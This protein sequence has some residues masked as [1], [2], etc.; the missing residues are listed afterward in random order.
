[1]SQI[2]EEIRDIVD[3]AEPVGAPRSKKPRVPKPGDPRPVEGWKDPMF[4][5]GWRSRAWTNDVGLPRDCPVHPLGK[6]GDVFFFLDPLGQLRALKASEMGQAGIAALFAPRTEY[7]YWGWP[8]FSKD[9]EVVGWKANLIRDDLMN[10]CAHL[11]VWRS[12]SRV[13]GRG[14]WMEDDGSLTLHC[15]DV[16]VRANGEEDPGERGDFV[17]PAGVKCLKPWGE[18]VNGQAAQDLLDLLSTWRWRR[19]IDPLLLLGWISAGIL[20]G[21]LRW[22]PMMFLVGDRATGKSTLQRVISEVFGPDGMVQAAETTAAGI[23]QHVRQ[24]SVP[25]SID[26]MEAEADNRKA[27]AVV[28]LARLASSGALMLRGGAEHKGVEFT[29]RSVFGFSAINAPPMRP[30]DRSRMAFLELRPFQPG[31]KEPVIDVEDLR[32]IGRKI[33]RRL[34]DH[35]GE[36][37]ERLQTIRTALMAGGHVGR[38]A[39]QFGALLV[40]ADLLLNDTPPSSDDLQEW[41]ESLA[42]DDMVEFQDADPN[43]QRCLDHLFSKPVKA[44]GRDRMQTVGAQLADLGNPAE[45]DLAKRIENINNRLAQIG[46]AIV[47]NFDAAPGRKREFTGLWLAIPTTDAKLQ[48][49]F[50]GTDWAGSAGVGGIWSGALRQAP[51]GYWCN[52]RARIDGRQRRCILVN[53]DKIMQD[54]SE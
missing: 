32:I 27:E 45:G 22:R 25:I 23:Y 40:C 33:R 42:P 19:S 20:G 15:G 18:H 48:D 52:D 44:W 29:A 41:A 38:G 14:G 8:Q 31:D 28:K 51:D 24:D 6:D 37:D 16:L 2:E 9:L 50:E 34:L 53:L 21:F 35:H 7:L 3:A 11:G 39:D 54:G 1:M 4:A 30:Q 26:E 47:G 46:L 36:L 17:Y 12:A 13:R 10:A 49:H 43:W 5:G